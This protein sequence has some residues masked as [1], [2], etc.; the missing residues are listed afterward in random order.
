MVFN[1]SEFGMGLFDVLAGAKEKA[2]LSGLEH[3]DVVEGVS[4]G[5]ALEVEFSECFHG[6]AF[7]VCQPENMLLD[8]PVGVNLERMAK[9]SELSELLK[10]GL[11]VVLKGIRQNE[12]SRADGVQGAQHFDGARE[13]FHGS[14]CVAH[15]FEFDIVAFQNIDPKIHQF[16]IVWLLSGCDLQLLKAGAPLHLQPDFRNQNAFTIKAQRPHLGIV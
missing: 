13:G 1:D 9:H 15:V 2:H 14:D 8:K 7:L 11:R 6:L 16:V 3:G 12:D 4:D 5:D 10:H